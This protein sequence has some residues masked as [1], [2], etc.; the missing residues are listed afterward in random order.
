MSDRQPRPST[1]AGR[2]STDQSRCAGGYHSVLTSEGLPQR[3][4]AIR[5]A[6]AVPCSSAGAAVAAST[7]K[8]RLL[9][10]LAGETTGCRDVDQLSP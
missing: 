5:S 7:T 10:V 9:V 3:R 8:T 2:A 1:E 4:P 6:S